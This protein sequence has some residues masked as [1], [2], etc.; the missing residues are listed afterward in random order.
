[1]S[2]IESLRQRL[3]SITEEE[4]RECNALLDHREV[5][6][7][8]VKEL[9]QLA[10]SYFIPDYQ[11]GYRWTELEVETLLNDISLASQQ[12]THCLQPL[13][14][15]RRKENNRYTVIDG[16]QRLTTISIILAWCATKDS[17]LHESIRPSIGYQTRINSK[18]FL[19][20]IS[21]KTDESNVDFYNMT[22]AYNCCRNSGKVPGDIK[23]RLLNDCYFILYIVNDSAN[24][25][26]IFKRLNSGKIDLTNAELT[27]ALLLHGRDYQEQ[28]E[29]ALHW[30]EM[31]RFF[32]N[33]DF[34]YFICSNSESERYTQTRLD[35]LIELVAKTRSNYDRYASFR[36]IYGKKEYDSVWDCL[37]RYYQILRYWYED[38]P[39]HSGDRKR[40]SFY[41]LVGF[42][43]ASGTDVETLLAVFGEKTKT[44]CRKEFINTIKQGFGLPNEDKGDAKEKLGELISGR[45]YGRDNGQIAKILLLMN[46]ATLE[47]N[48][49]EYSRYP[50]SLHHREKWSLEHIHARQ[51]GYTEDRLRSYIQLLEKKGVTPP[52][53]KLDKEMMYKECVDRFEHMYENGDFSYETSFGNLALLPRGINSKFKNA[54]YNEKR[55]MLVEE[56]NSGK[57]SVI[58]I[59]TRY[60][61][62]KY[63]S[64]E[65]DSNLVWDGKNAFDYTSKAIEL[66]HYYLY[67]TYSL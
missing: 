25:Y 28:V 55:K 61:F 7:I 37:M 31:V 10:Y 32:E 49:G 19:D 54:G 3:D 1:M 42:L 22:V 29:M 41:H 44:E 43:V 26:E 16:Q 17:S 65:D 67:H 6:A 2:E 34:W 66:I 62:F 51:E 4:A 58:P 23:N 35:F 18:E 14:L 63:Y 38:T 36:A 48:G 46:I 27:K 59:C 64:P 60:A 39:S 20:N 33:D 30:D 57:L 53:E 5:K 13:V 52:D 21:D 15:Q 40:Q 24:E 8:S 56:C 47:L 11:R 45:I 12:H 9:L 50:F